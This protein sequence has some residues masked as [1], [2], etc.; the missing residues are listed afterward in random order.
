V[1][2]RAALAGVSEAAGGKR[3]WRSDSASM[4]LH[5]AVVARYALM[6][7]LVRGAL[8]YA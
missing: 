4:P 6:L 7:L 5:A 8:I 2:G 1:A 3:E